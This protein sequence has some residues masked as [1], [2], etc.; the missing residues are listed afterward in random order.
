MPAWTDY[1]SKT[2]PV[3][4]DE[5]MIKD[6][7]D[8]SKANKRLLFSGLWNWIVNKLT[9]AV[10]ANLETSPQTIVG[11]LNSLNK[12][13]IKNTKGTILVEGTDLLTLP[14]GDYCADSNVTASTLVNS[15][16][17]YNFHLTVRERL[18]NKRLFMEIVD[19]NCNIYYN[20]QISDDTWT[21]WKK[22]T[23]T[24]VD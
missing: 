5:I 22:V 12:D 6:Y 15:P 23:T 9:N 21:G 16:T 17:Q 8:S 11:A 19:L 13:A 7:S 2:T 4:T 18:W 10:I 20:C 24:A 1:T 14:K 3:D